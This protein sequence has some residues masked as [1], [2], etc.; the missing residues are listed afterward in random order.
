MLHF[1]CQWSSLSA[2]K[3]S[4]RGLQNI[5]GYSKAT[6]SFFFSKSIAKRERTT[7]QTSQQEGATS[8]K[9][10]RISKIKLTCKTCIYFDQNGNYSVIAYPRPNPRVI[11]RSETG[12]YFDNISDAKTMSLSHFVNYDLY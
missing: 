4:F 11:Y 1:I 9:Q 5:R 10:M 8:N 12:E 3:Y 7:Q 6:I 2:K